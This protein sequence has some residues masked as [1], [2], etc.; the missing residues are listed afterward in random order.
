MARE[1]VCKESV[2]VARVGEC[3]VAS[4][5]EREAAE[6]C[7]ELDLAITRFGNATDGSGRWEG[8]IG[9]VNGVRDQGGEA[10]GE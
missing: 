5:D 6:N 8:D 7:E 3:A 2:G 10:E 4:E 9:A 1:M